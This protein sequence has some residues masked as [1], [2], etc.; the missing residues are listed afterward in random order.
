M[1][2]IDGR[3]GSPKLR[4]VIE[5]DAPG[6][7]PDDEG[8]LVRFFLYLNEWD[9]EAMIGTRSAEHSRLDISGKDRI[10]QYVKDYAEAYPNL[11]KHADGYPDPEQ[12]RKR[13]YQ[14]F[15]GT[16][17]RDAVIAIVDK[18]DPRPIWFLN[19]GTNEE[20]NVPTSLRQALDHVQ[21]TRSVAAYRAFA[22]KLHYIE[23]VDPPRAFIAPH[24][25]A[26]GFYMDTFFPVMDGGRWYHRF[27]PLTSKAG[28]FDI[29]RDIKKDHG[30]LMA[31]YT[32]VKEGDTPT[33]MHLIPNGL[34]DPM[35]PEWG[36]WSGRFG[37]NVEEGHWWV[38]QRDRW[39][40]ETSRDST[41][42]R[43]A[44]HLQNDFRARADWCVRANKN[45][46][47]HAP[48][49]HLEGDATRDTLLFRRPPGQQVSLSAKG[50]SDPDGDALQ[51]R[52]IHYPE[53][54]TYRNE[55]SL[56]GAETETC[57]LT[58]PGDAGGK[59]IHMILQVTDAGTPALTRYRRAIVTGLVTQP[60]RKARKKSAK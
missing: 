49:V 23:H 22:A 19:W 34:Q 5:T 9:V 16:E 58:V 21:A 29:D 41:L 4:V 50:S 51:Y 15:T 31:N 6:G 17:A 42:R 52:W 59:T 47:N 26:L 14:C 44:V 10:L 18:P 39:E 40:G 25:Y 3:V 56:E 11:R 13:V 30:P 32:I 48:V 27:A 46:A 2:A 43:W 36:T 7:D 37:F 35:H 45:E 8:S 12:L 1:P 55:V 24:R 57:R 53:A 20:D 28:G 60:P 54:G 33:F 38:D